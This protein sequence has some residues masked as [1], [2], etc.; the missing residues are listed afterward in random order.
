MPLSVGE[1][2]GAYEILGLLG[3]GGMGEVYRARDTRLD[4]TVALK[5]LRTA[6]GDRE[7]QALLA[8]FEREARAIS[9]LNHP[10]IC[11]LYDVGKDAGLDYLVMEYVH[12]EAMADTLARGAL[13]I[14][15]ALRHAIQIAA[16][17]GQAHRCGVVHRDLKPANIMLTKTGIKLLDFGLAKA[18]SVPA[19]SPETATLT[20]ALTSE[21][22]IVGT[23]QYMA[24][25]QLEG[26]EADARSDIFAFG[27]V[28]YEM[29]AGRRAFEGSSQASVIA[30]IIRAEVPPI[31]ALPP[32][33]ERVL[34]KCL[35]KDPE[36]RWQN[37]LDL[38]DE[39]EWISTQPT[40]KPPLPVPV[41]PRRLVWAAVGV[42]IGLVVPAPWMVRLLTPPHNAVLRMGVAGI[43]KLS[44]PGAPNLSPDGKYLAFEEWG[45]SG[46]HRLC[47]RALD[48]LSVTPI[49]GSDDPAEPFWSPD[50]RS[51]AFAVNS[52]HKLKRFDLGAGTAHTICDL[53]ANATFGGTWN[54]EGTILIP[55]SEKGIY[56]VHASGGSPMPVT[57]IDS[58]AGDN[59]HRYPDFLPD[60][61]HFLYVAVNRAQGNGTIYVGSLDSQIRKRLLAASSR[62]VYAS[63]HLLFV[64]EGTLWGQSF[65][66]KNLSLF[67][68]PHAIADDVIHS[69]GNAFT[70]FSASQNGVVAYS[71]QVPPDLG[72]FSL[73]RSGKQTRLF[74]DAA[75]QFTS[76]RISPDQVYLAAAKSRKADESD[77][78]LGRLDRGTLSLLALP[79]A[80]RVWPVW[81]RDSN[82]IAY[83][84][85]GAGGWDL[86][87]YNIASAG[88]EEVLLPSTG[89]SA[90]PPRSWSPDGRFLLYYDISAQSLNILPLA[91]DRQPHPLSKAHGREGAI[92]PDGHWFAYD[93]SASGRNELYIHSF[94]DP[95]KE[96]QVTSGGASHAFFWTRVGKELL[97]QD[98]SGKLI[99]V[100][101]QLGSQAVLGASHELFALPKGAAIED[102]SA[103]GERII[104]SIPVTE[105]D[106]RRFVLVINWPDAFRN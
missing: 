37:A 84:R 28:L 30:S 4:R 24:P 55:I 87:A 5:I 69:S 49:A 70:L 12:G 102:V 62:P 77:L 57:S 46:K 104:A 75:G 27:A 93:S 41:P 60:G 1:R 7:R 66:V 38:K 76:V 78:W 15:H 32:P 89:F 52:E 72:I 6:F 86:C 23:L 48:G 17:L 14:E 50:S 79:A 59:A 9:S 45:P 65:D 80:T 98:L 2:L 58:A 83:S 29:I 36:D 39:L 31:S 20:A 18:A 71:R 25:E 103:D 85:H 63:G 33:L 53:P 94:P 34:R 95:G 99:S 21:G 100:T 73:D 22:T 51:V 3:A 35:A 61:L 74:G 88:Q 81:S 92:S 101:V 10:Y 105:G 106:Q 56:K 97:Y 47:L 40:E 91:G 64:R 16:A 68:E 96:Y 54:R 44:T 90:F 82:R 19:G 26:R 13:P 8:R 67:G 42:V 11:A 43:E